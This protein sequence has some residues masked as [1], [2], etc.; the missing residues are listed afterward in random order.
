[1]YKCSS[2]NLEMVHY[3]IMLVHLLNVK[4]KLLRS[5][6]TRYL[7][8]V[9]PHPTFEKKN[10]DLGE[11]LVGKSY[12]KKRVKFFILLLMEVILHHLRCIKPCKYWD[13]YHINWLAGFQPSTVVAW[14]IVEYPLFQ[15][16]SRFWKFILCPEHLVDPT[17]SP[18]YWGKSTLWYRYTNVMPLPH[19]PMHPKRFT[20]R[21]GKRNIIFKSGKGYV[22]VPRRVADK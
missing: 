15:R 6:K 11:W 12:W 22:I 5:R 20:G 18:V 8:P 10:H 1:M 14:N 2:N 7:G 4:T 16:K 21:F 9:S 3:S 13:I 17:T 19:Q